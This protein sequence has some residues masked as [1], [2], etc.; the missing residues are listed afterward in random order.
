MISVG[1]QGHHMYMAHVTWSFWDHTFHEGVIHVTLHPLRS[2]NAASNLLVEPIPTCIL[3]ISTN[4][5]SSY[6]H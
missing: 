6:F 3:S 2:P 5:A 1:P 4:R